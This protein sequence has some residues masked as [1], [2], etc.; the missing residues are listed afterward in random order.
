MIID[1]ACHCGSITFTAE[2]DPK[3]VTICHCADCQVLSGAPFRTVVTAPI[4]RFKLS[5]EPRRYTVVQSG[6]P[7][8]QA[9]CPECGTPLFAAAPES[10]T[11]VVLRLGCVNQRAQLRPS[12]QIWAN[13]ALPWISELSLL[14]KGP[15]ET[16]A[17]PSTSTRGS[18]A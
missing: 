14:R 6:K 3:G 15:K 13:V 5:G 2:I 12:A 17:L 1:G 11:F 9:F 10:P 16:D 8:A 4:E 18:D 7:M